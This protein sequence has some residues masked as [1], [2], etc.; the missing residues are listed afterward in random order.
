MQRSASIGT[1]HAARVVIVYAR[2]AANAGAGAWSRTRSP[3]GRIAN[4]TPAPTYCVRHRNLTI[5]LDSTTCLVDTFDPWSTRRRRRSMVADEFPR[6]LCNT[7]N[8]SW[9]TTKTLYNER[10]NDACMEEYD[11]YSIMST[12]RSHTPSKRKLDNGR[13]FFIN[14]FLNCTLRKLSRI[15]K[16]QL[17]FRQFFLETLLKAWIRLSQEARSNVTAYSIGYPIV[18]RIRCSSRKGLRSSRFISRTPHYGS[19][20]YCHFL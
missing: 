9:S 12:S 18:T 19:K 14:F 5:W 7:D 3:T 13:Y 8:S 2:C 1:T 10:E 4:D 16:L 20:A 11:A 17:S 15:V 6:T